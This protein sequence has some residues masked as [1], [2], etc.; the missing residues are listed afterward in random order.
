[1]N[2]PLTQ[3]ASPRPCDKCGSYGAAWLAGIGFTMSLFISDLAFSDDSLV[4]AAKLGILAA[5]LM[6][7]VVGCTILR[8]AGT[9]F[10]LVLRGVS[11]AS[12]GSRRRSGSLACFRVLR[13]SKRFLQVG[14]AG[15]EPATPSL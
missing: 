12:E 10:A 8:T 5:S 13:L 11:V 4:E 15:F 14:D 1:M 7:G 9:P 6:A 2:D 3:S